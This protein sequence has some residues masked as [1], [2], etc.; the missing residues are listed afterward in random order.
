MTDKNT[1]SHALAD[2]AQRWHGIEIDGAEAEALS[3]AYGLWKDTVSASAARLPMDSVPGDFARVMAE[4]APQGPLR[5]LREAAAVARVGEDPLQAEMTQVAAMLR[6]LDISARE[7]TQMSLRALH[8]V[9]E[10]I[11]APKFNYGA[12]RIAANHLHVDGSLQLVHDHQSD[13]RGLDLAR[14][15]RVLEYIGRVWRRPVTLHTVGERGEAR[16]VT[17]KRL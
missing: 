16:V 7:L 3:G 12:P 6:Q 10:A 1:W 14:A 8:A 5:L 2:A 4:A 15:E 11:L 9:H 13:G 17:S